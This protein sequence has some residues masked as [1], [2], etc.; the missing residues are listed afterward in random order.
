M[1]RKGA[2]APT[3][4]QRNAKILS[5]YLSKNFGKITVIRAKHYQSESK[6]ISP[7]GEEIDFIEFFKVLHS[8]SPFN[9]LS[10]NMFFT[11]VKKNIC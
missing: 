10:K 9:Q 4:R 8:Q 6:R 7:I 3:A 2:Y 5:L 11:T 1:K